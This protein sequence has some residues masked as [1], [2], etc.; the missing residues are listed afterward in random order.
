MNRV[1]E[2]EIMT[3]L[4]NTKEAAQVLAVTKGTLE[5]W[6]STR[7]YPLRYVKVGRKVMYRTADLEKFLA[8]RTMPGVSEQHSRRSRRAAA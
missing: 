8:D 6:R 7:R 1:R 3:Q 2:E 4:L 5:V